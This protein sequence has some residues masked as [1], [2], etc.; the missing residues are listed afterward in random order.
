MEELDYEVEDIRGKFMELV[1]SSYEVFYRKL[2][3]VGNFSF[4]PKEKD[5]TSISKFIDLICNKYDGIDG[6]G[7]NY[8]YNY[9][10]F[11]LDYW[12][13]L[14][15]RFN[16]KIPLSWFIGKKAFERW[17]NRIEH[18]LWHAHKTANKYGLNVGSISKVQ[19]SKKAGEINQ[20]EEI[21]KGR[22]YGTESGLVNCLE[23]TSLYNHKSK[24]CMSCMHKKDCKT[25]LKSEFPKIYILRG[26]LK[27]E[28]NRV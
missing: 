3:G 5:K 7:R 8:I 17:E 23:A 20:S 24:L 25:I 1:A 14:D 13:G 27:S 26:Y 18:D 9:F 16:N 12:A 15:T 2:S 6:I 4:E 19:E 11:Q 28:K 10:V 21:E 22:F